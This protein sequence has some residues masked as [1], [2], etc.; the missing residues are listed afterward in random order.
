MHQAKEMYQFHYMK[1]ILSTLTHLPHLQ[2][3]LNIQAYPSTLVAQAPMKSTTNRRHLNQEELLSGVPSSSTNTPH[4]RKF[5]SKGVQIKLQQMPLLQLSFPTRTASV[6]MNNTSTAQHPF[7]TES[8]NTT[9]SL[10]ESTI[11][12]SKLIRKAEKGEQRTKHTDDAASTVW[13]CT[14]IYRT[15]RP[16]IRSIRCFENTPTKL[17]SLKLLQLHSTVIVLERCRPPPAWGFSATM[18]ENQHH[19]TIH[20]PHTA[21]YLARAKSTSQPFP[22]SF[23]G[24][25]V[26]G[27]RLGL[28]ASGH[29][30]LAREDGNCQP[31]MSSSPL[32][33]TRVCGGGK[34]V[35]CAVQLSLLQCNE[36]EWEFAMG[37]EN[38][39]LFGAPRSSGTVMGWRNWRSVSQDILT[40][41]YC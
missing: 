5:N 29:T 2:C 23:G 7:A 25:C 30:L 6:D 21:K 12:S 35:T 34:W 1:K 9:Q 22:R 27:K 33:E 4:W 41:V 16:I 18:L 28:T 38:V 39:F 3:P 36:V 13:T 40:W 31:P 24:M 10:K 14:R 37:L 19:P 20:P 17:R 8:V 26:G 11:F 32:A 15:K